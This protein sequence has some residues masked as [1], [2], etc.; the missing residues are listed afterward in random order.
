MPDPIDQLRAALPS[1]YTLLH[2]LRQGG[3]GAVFLGTLRG[4]QVALKFFSAVDVERLRREIDLLT[5]VTSPHLVR[6]L[7]FQV[8]SVA[9]VD[10][11]MI[12]Y[13]YVT[14]GDLRTVIAGPDQVPGVEL[15]AAGQQVGEAIEVLWSKRIV[16][17]DIKPENVVR[18]A[19]NRFVLVDVGFAQHIDLTTITAPAGQPGTNG[20]RSPEQCGGRRKLT[21]HSD[22]FSLGVTL[23]EVAG[24][25][26]PWNRNQA[27]MGRT[28]PAPLVTI[29]PDLDPRLVNLIHEMMRAIPSRRPFNPA[30]RFQQLGGP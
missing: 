7:E 13:E 5:S 26:H 20:Y 22:V 23:F 4:V 12:A 21:V 29:R 18:A 15:V 14:G 11:P 6:L 1:G 24:K 2:P 28:A 8:I 25:T 10:V 3:Q 30:E 16:H 19:S 9:G 17:R 27:L